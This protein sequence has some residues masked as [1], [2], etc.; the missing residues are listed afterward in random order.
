M[1]EHAESNLV[2]R[3]FE[4]HEIR[5]VGALVLVVVL[6]A[7]FDSQHVYWKTPLDSL[8]LIVRPTCILG[9]FA[10]GSA[11]VIISGGIDLSSGSMLAMG[12]T[13]CASIMLLLDQ[14]GM[15]GTNR[16]VHFWVYCVAISGTL[17]VG[18]LVGSLH[19]WLI[20]VVRLPP[21]IATLATL[22]GLRSLARAIIERVQEVVIG[23]RST[24]INL[25]DERFRTL[26]EF[27]NTYFPI[28]LVLFVV[29]A[30]LAWLMMSKT[31]VGRHLYAMGGNEQAA[32]LSGI[33]TDSLKWLAYVISAMLSALAGVI[34]ICDQSVAEPQSL[35]MGYE[36]NAIAAAVVGGCSLQG[37]V[38]AIPG[39]V[40]GCLFLRT[41]INGVARII[42][43]GAEVYEG[44]V[45][46]IV[47]VCAVAF[48]EFRQGKQ[49][50]RQFFPGALGWVAAATLGLI[51]GCLYGL[52][53][54]L[55]RGVQVGSV[56]TALFVATKIWQARSTRAALASGPPGED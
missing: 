45:V 1:S 44:L 31:V 15:E 2:R 29:I 7:V 49:A 9:I 13:V 10:L 12:G 19:A 50:H 56:L 48:A 33:R 30:L 18:F 14:E 4:R 8:K 39:V 51:L 23:S 20:T 46:G 21:F 24:Q 28:P 40:L 3:L 54:G 5:L 22:V 27:S 17:L 16:P 32:R 6:V 25:F 41:V 11:I 47:V 37:G 43:S 55:A 53:G 42:N 34:A 52:I 35:G 38:G 26:A 36:L